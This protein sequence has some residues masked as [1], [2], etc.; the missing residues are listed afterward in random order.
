MEWSAPVAIR[1]Q[2]VAAELGSLIEHSPDLISL[3]DLEGSLLYMNDAGRRLVGLDPARPLDT[4]SMVD[5]VAPEW[6]E[7]LRHEILPAVRDTGQWQGEMQ[8]MHMVTGERIDVSRATHL[9]RDDSTGEPVGFGTVSRDIRQQKR[10]EQHFRTLADNMSQLAWMAE[11]DGSIFWYNRRWLEYTGTSLD[12]TRG[13]GW[14]SV[15]HPDH[16]ERVEA[17][18]RRSIAAGEEWEDTFPIRGAD[19]SWRW[20]LSR[21]QPIRDDEGRVV[22]WFGTNTDITDLR[23]AQEALRRADRLKDEFL[24]TLSHE[25]RTP[26]T[27]V[28]GWTQLLMIGTLT[29]D[30]RQSAVDA[31]LRSALAQARLIEDML[32]ISRITA[33]KMRLDLRPEDPA[34]IAEVAASTIVPA[35]E[36]KG[37]R[38]E[39]DLDGD[40]GLMMVDADRV[41]Q[42]LWNLLSNAI[43]FAPPRSRVKLKL[44]REGESAVFEVS[45]NGPGIAADFVPHLFERFRQADG[46]SRRSFGGLGVGLAIVEQLT[47]LHGGSVSVETVLEKGS[48]FRV[49]LPI[50]REK[51]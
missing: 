24:A 8:L 45:D 4:V 34:R 18:Y 9:V 20:F 47:H 3:A 21:A 36:A 6:V 15:H 48:T 10:A 7:R 26:L 41:Q 37:T 25:L 17:K 33:G 12:T 39:I 38:L 32:D 43:K 35:A 44:A 46:S 23:E 13:F 50:V 30:E 5:Y 40:I 51:Q 14:R 49:Q 2:G 16:V 28:L 22:R 19:G 29:H 1:L 31:I 42:I 11:P 27:A